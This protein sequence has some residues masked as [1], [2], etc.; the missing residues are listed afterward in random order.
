VAVYK[1]SNSG[2]NTRREYTSFL[3]GNDP[4]LIPNSYDSIATTTVGSGGSATI[5]FSS[6]PQTYKHLQLRIFTVNSSY[7]TASFNGDTTSTNYRAHA[8][9]GTGAAATSVAYTNVIYMPF[10]SADSNNPFSEVIDILDYTNTNKNKVTRSL[11]GVDKNGGS[12]QVALV[13][14]LWMSTSAITSISMAVNSGVFGQ[15]SRFA[16]YGV[17]G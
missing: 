14:G 12:G 5:T 1:T 11:A 13:S 17:E 2:L 7:G 6:I 4:F 9:V 15:N 8:L 16:L 10:D 3:A